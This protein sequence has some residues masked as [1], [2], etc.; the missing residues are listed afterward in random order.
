M[1]CG[2]TATA[3]RCARAQAPRRTHGQYVLLRGGGGVAGR[4][5]E[6]VSGTADTLA[7]PASRLGSRLKTT[8]GLLAMMLGTPPAVAI[9]RTERAGAVERELR[10]QR[11]SRAGRAANRV[12]MNEHAARLDSG[13]TCHVPRGCR[14]LVNESGL[15][16]FF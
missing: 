8:T 7:Q 13:A 9:A 5:R 2:A 1:A 3:A 12:D 10:Q 16:S 14:R 11:R 4:G 6:R 15:S